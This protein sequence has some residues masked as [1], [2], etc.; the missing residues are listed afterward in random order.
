MAKFWRRSQGRAEKSFASRANNPASCVVHR[1]ENF[2]SIFAKKHREQRNVKI[3]SQLRV[4]F[5]DFTHMKEVHIRIFS[6]V[7]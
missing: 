3:I 5:D 2:F 7:Q 4:F 1:K 6:Q